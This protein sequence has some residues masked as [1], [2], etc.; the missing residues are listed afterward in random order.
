[1]IEL[2]AASFS[3]GVVL[4]SDFAVLMGLSV[5]GG[6]SSFFLFVAAVSVSIITC[7][8]RRMVCGVSEVISV[9]VVVIFKF[10]VFSSLIYVVA[11]AFPAEWVVDIS[12]W[13]ASGSGTWHWFDQCLVDAHRWH[14]CNLP[15]MAIR[16]LVD[17]FLKLI[18]M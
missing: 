2:I 7:C 15:V 10:V 17:L 1:M 5:I 4:S 11:V 16:M 3:V 18:L 6:L 13:V 14:A 12:S 9:L 8:C